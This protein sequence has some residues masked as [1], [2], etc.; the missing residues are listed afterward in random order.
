MKE[1]A[2]IIV[3]GLHL[4]ATVIWVGGITFVLLVAM[5]SA[6]E[7]MGVDAGRIMSAI[8]KRFTPLANYSILLLIITGI[9]LTGLNKHYSGIGNL[10]DSNWGI[11]LGLKHVVVLAMISIH[12][13]RGLILT[14]KIAK[15]TSVEERSSW[16]KLSLNLVQTNFVL[17]IIVLLFSGIASVS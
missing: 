9:A 7:V 17:G 6:R 13:Y 10:L 3:Y 5:P 11:A 2:L 16:Q 15:A 14:P 1:L 4:L 12:F 8:T